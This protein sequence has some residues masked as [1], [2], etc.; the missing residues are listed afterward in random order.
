VNSRSSRTAVVTG[1]GSG[2]G[3][4][5]ALQLLLAGWR[6]A[7]VGRRQRPLD[8]T[9]ALAGDAASQL[10]TFLCDIGVRDDVERMAA[11]A[12]ERLAE[13]DAVVCAAGTNAA[14]RGWLELSH[15]TY[16]ELM[17]ANLHG[18]FH[19]VQ[20]FLPQMRAR[21]SGTFVFINSEAGR[22]ASAKSGVA[23]SA[24]K[25]G[26][27]GLAQSLNA[28][29]RQNGIRACSIFPGDVDTPLLDKRPVAPTAAA[30]AGMLQPGD[31]AACALLALSL[32]PRAIVE[33]LV[34]RPA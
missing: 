5:I 29:E 17:D 8:E 14:K 2:I 26:L 12:T 24:A 30:R 33:E 19:C 22:R 32:P 28:E 11:R 34:I 20:A 16:R 6:V 31:V 25:F 10:M 7:L 23:Y 9:A 15:E 27:A 18:A 3:R 13:V 1:A 4:A 21:R